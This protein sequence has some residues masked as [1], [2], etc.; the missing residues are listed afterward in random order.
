MILLDTHALVWYLDDPQNLS[1]RAE[2]TISAGFRGEG[3]AISDITL[4][5]IAMLVQKGRLT[6]ARDVEEWLADL[7]TLPNFRKYRISSTVA[8]LSTRLPDGFH[9]DP[10]DRLIVATALDLGVP[11]VTRDGRI[12]AYPYIE[13]VW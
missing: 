4:W 9:G 7:N 5:E 8:A 13:A 6:F 11:L 3:A 1:R 12:R 10:A 2:E